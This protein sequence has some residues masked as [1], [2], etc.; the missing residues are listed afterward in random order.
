MAY[1]STIMLKNM[2]RQKV[3]RAVIISMFLLLPVT[4]Y[5]FSPVLS[6]QAAASGIVSGSL[7]V[8]G[9]LFIASLFL[10]RLFCGWVCPAG[11]AQELVMRFREKPVNPRRIGWIKYLVWTPWVAVLVFLTLQAGGG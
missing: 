8:F 11:G 7:V 5:Y 9:I 1:L 2:K 3:R 6:L 4:L 10:G